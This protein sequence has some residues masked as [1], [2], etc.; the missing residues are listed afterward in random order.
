[1][2][3]KTKKT[4]TKEVKAIEG[5]MIPF[6]CILDIARQFDMHGSEHELNGYTL[7]ASVGAIGREIVATLDGVKLSEDSPART[8]LTDASLMIIDLSIILDELSHD[9]DDWQDGMHSAVGVMTHAMALNA[10]RLVEA[11]AQFLGAKHLHGFSD[12]SFGSAK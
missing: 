12:P 1:M 6:L 3:T 10:A 9:S 7:A 8:R 5:T 4:F 2:S 11:A